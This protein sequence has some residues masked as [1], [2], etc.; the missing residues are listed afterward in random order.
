MNFKLLKRPWVKVLIYSTFIVIAIIVTSIVAFSYYGTPIIE[1]KINKAL[2]KASGGIYQ[3]K[4]TEARIN[5]FRGEIVISDLTLTADTAAYLS[6]KKQKAVSDK[7]YQL[8]VQRVVLS[9]THPF[10]LWFNKK[11][12]V[13]EI[14]LNAPDVTVTAYPDNAKFQKPKDNRT[15]F[16]RLSNSLKSLYVGHIFFKN[17]K[18]HYKDV[19]TMKPAVYELE[20]LDLSAH[21]LLI[22]SATQFDRT[23]LLFCK[24]L[25]VALHNYQGRTAKGLYGSKVKLIDFSTR[26]RMLRLQGFVMRPSLKPAQFFQKTFQDQF[27]LQSNS[28]LIENFYYEIYNKSHA[29]KAASI[30]LNTG[31]IS[32]FSNYHT[33]PKSFHIDKVNTFPNKALQLVPV[34]IKVDTIQLRHYTVAYHEYNI[35]AK[36]RGYITFNE[37]GGQFVN[38]TNDSAAINKN[39]FCNASLTAKFMNKAPMQVAFKFDLK[40]SLYS[41]RYKGFVGP[42]NM[43]AVNVAT[44]P[45][46]SLNMQSGMAKRIDFDISA[47]RYLAKGKVTFLYNNLKIQLL[48]AD[49]AKL[50]MRRLALVSLLANKLIIKDNN[51]DNIKAK[52]RFKYVIYERPKTYPFFKTIWRTLLMGIKSCAGLDFQAQREADLKQAKKEKEKYWKEHKKEFRKQKRAEKRRVKKLKKLA[53]QRIQR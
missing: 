47:N 3:V 43:Q 29:I 12:D 37:I 34:K 44:V 10:K 21:D 49:S 15:I 8:H 33:D 22:D 4:L 14:S 17:V 25:N 50:K 46:A 27:S 28:I 20:E 6:Q 5:L 39:P 16:Q 52:P 24:E 30:T 32:V 19:S 35:K 42:I 36:R 53:K 41:Y 23:R 18:L 9:H 38:V 31:V 2:Y 13:T 45:L 51:P 48:K 7:L 40:D 26:T 1:N 11:L